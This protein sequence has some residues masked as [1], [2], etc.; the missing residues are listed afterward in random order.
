MGDRFERLVT[1]AVEVMATPCGKHLSQ[2]SVVDGNS[3]SADESTVNVM[4]VL[5]FRF[6]DEGK[7]ILI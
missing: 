1:V 2:V 7:T 3:G 5:R 4:F 6:I